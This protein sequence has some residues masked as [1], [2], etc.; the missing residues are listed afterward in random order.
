MHK[1]L[2]FQSKM[3]MPESPFYQV[4]NKN[5]FIF[6]ISIIIHLGG[7]GEALRTRREDAQASYADG[8]GPWLDRAG[9]KALL[10]SAETDDPWQNTF[11]LFLSHVLLHSTRNVYA[12]QMTSR[13]GQEENKSFVL[14]GRLF[15]NGTT[16][17]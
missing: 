12:L 6:F 10:G 16:F 3:K 4:L 7:A 5:K 2:H 14:L 11:C 13:I 15:G 17:L 1:N 8:E 9:I